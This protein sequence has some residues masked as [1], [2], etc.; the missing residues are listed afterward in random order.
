MKISN[1][2]VVMNSIR[3]VVIKLMIKGIFYVKLW[4]PEQVMKIFHIFVWEMGSMA[5][6]LY[7]VYIHIQELSLF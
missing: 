2:A 3:T 7:T 1:T 6:I 4:N 5:Y